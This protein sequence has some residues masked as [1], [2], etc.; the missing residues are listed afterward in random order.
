MSQQPPPPPYGGPPG[1]YPP[2]P[3]PQGPGDQPAG[4]S[5]K[6]KFWLGV[7]LT[8][9][10]LFLV[11]VVTSVPSAILDAMDADPSIGGVIGFMLLLAVLGLFVTGIVLERTRWFTLGLLA[12]TAVLFV[13]AA[14][15]CVALLVAYSNSSG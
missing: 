11:G 2:Q 7:L 8:I 9:P 4:R 1:P 10:A 15:A 6:T 3:Y 12:G 14:G 5:N 13:L